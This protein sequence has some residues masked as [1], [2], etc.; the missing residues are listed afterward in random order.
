MSRWFSYG[1]TGS[2][3]PGPEHI[4]KFNRDYG[5]AVMYDTGK[6][7]MPAAAET[8]D[9]TRRT[10][11]LGRR[12][13]R[14]RKSTSIRPRLPGRMPAPC[15]H[16]GDISTPPCCRTVKF[17][18]PGVSAAAGSN[19]IGT[20]VRTAEIWNP[21]TNAWTT[22][23]AGSVNRGYHSVSLLLPDGTVLHGAS[24]DAAIPGG[25]GAIYPAEKNHQIFSPP[26]LFKGVRPTIGSAPA[27]VG[28]NETFTVNTAYAAQI[29]SV[30]WIRL[31]SVT[32]AFD[33]NQRANTPELHCQRWKCAGHRPLESGPGTA[34]SLPALYSQPQRRSL[35]GKGRPGPVIQRAARLRG[36]LAS[37]AC[38]THPLSR[39][40]SFRRLTHLR[41]QKTLS[42]TRG[43]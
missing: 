11:S 34:G 13:P 31:G 17:W 25:G 23:A 1:G 42:P 24:G 28:Y 12:R 27:T 35:G 40:V 30:R 20:A 39:S 9:G 41:A 21:K 10:P 19:N 38:D 3:T 7:L 15:R 22:L 33:M 18:S 16:L 26:Y 5:T 37:G 14:P 2:W 43:K 6:I 29:A 32:H 36:K 4:W 8:P